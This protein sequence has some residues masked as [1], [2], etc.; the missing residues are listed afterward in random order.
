MATAAVARVENQIPLHA[1]KIVRRLDE[2]P[3]LQQALRDGDLARVRFLWEQLVDCD[4][5]Q[6]PTGELTPTLQAAMKPF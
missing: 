6:R 2:F 5:Q 4:G 1:D 3:E